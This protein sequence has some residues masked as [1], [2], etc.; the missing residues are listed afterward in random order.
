MSCRFI[1][2]LIL[3]FAPFCRVICQT[4]QDSIEA[5][6]VRYERFK[7]D[8]AK[9][10]KDSPI[11]VDSF[12][13]MLNYYTSVSN[14]DNPK[15][16]AAIYM[17]LSYIK[18][19]EAILEDIF[20]RYGF[21]YFMML[22]RTAIKNS[23][24]ATKEKYPYSNDEMATLYN[25][26]QEVLEQMVVDKSDLFLALYFKETM[27]YADLRDFDNIQKGINKW[28][29]VVNKWADAYSLLSDYY[30]CVLCFAKFLSMKMSRLGMGAQGVDLLSNITNDIRK[31]ENK[32]DD[33]KEAI[34]DVDVLAI[35]M[36]IN[37][38]PVTA[39]R[40]ASVHKGYFEFYDINNYLDLRAT[41]VFFLRDIDLD[42]CFEAAQSA[43]RLVELDR[44]G[45]NGRHATR[46]MRSLCYSQLSQVYVRKRQYR[47]ALTAILKAVEIDGD[48]VNPLSIH[49]LAAAYDHVGDFEKALDT[50]HILEEKGMMT[51]NTYSNMAGIAHREGLYE[52][53]N[54]YAEKYY[55]GI[56]SDFLDEIRYM[57]PRFRENNFNNNS[58]FKHLL[59]TTASLA[60]RNP[61]GVC[62]AYNASLFLK[63]FIVRINEETKHRIACCGSEELEKAYSAYLLG[64]ASSDE[65]MAGEAHAIMMSLF[66]KYLDFSLNDY[67][68]EWEDVWNALE[69]SEMA[70]EFVLCSDYDRME[71]RL[72]ALIIGKDYDQPKMVDLCSY[73]EF[74]DLFKATD[75][76]GCPRIYNQLEKPSQLLWGPLMEYLSGIETIY[77][78]PCIGLS[79]I[80]LDILT[81][82]AGGKPMNQVFNMRRMLSTAGLVDRKA[83]EK[84]ET[85]YLVGGVDYGSAALASV[86][87]AES[88]RGFSYKTG[89]D[90]L[91]TMSEVESIQKSCQK[92][93]KVSMLTGANAEESELKKRLVKSPSILHIATH[94]FY[95]EEKLAHK[96]AFY[97]EYEDKWIPDGLRSGVILS[98]SNDVWLGKRKSGGNDGTLTADEIN[99]LDLSGTEL[100]VL[101]ACQTGLGEYNAEGTY[102]LMRAF[103]NAGAG[104]IVMSLWE[105]NDE[106]TTLFMTTFY[107]RLV[108]GKDRYEAFLNAQEAVKKKYP[109]PNCWAAFVMLD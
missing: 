58:H 84:L 24:L 50:Y 43:V 69:E 10:G 108:S 81:A 3:L 49:N 14:G 12:L 6:N 42:Q 101:S 13:D 37:V 97:S 33:L 38:D 89:W 28:Y 70:I 65:S 54:E 5:L 83:E 39:F 85:A 90:P 96:Y 102:G 23:Q 92:K 99:G 27:L 100:V 86:S 16:R 44:T 73:K 1:I 52:E 74:R 21:D 9:Y 87:N 4:N 15:D 88:F 79:Q 7:N 30:K 36:L 2:P 109:S 34:E 72:A 93:M 51:V 82:G 105:V 59:E 11:V 18:K 76:Y 25:G 75:G 55:Y 80:N 47:D 67:T 78:S 66:P 64:L 71:L 103:K 107:S 60:Q 46:K 26:G 8:V 98:G 91:G 104:S 48:H 19:W 45:I 31:L 17:A 22:E 62:L 32:P 57:P 53:C 40:R 56:I 106:A 95:M 41:Y 77:Y 61:Y 20:S 35:K 94:G 63:G 68:I 29:N